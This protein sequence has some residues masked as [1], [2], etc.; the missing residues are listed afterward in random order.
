MPILPAEPE[1]YPQHPLAGGP[2]PGRSPPSLVVPPHQTAPGEDARPCPAQARDFPLSAPN[3]LREPD[4]GRAQD[5]VD[6][7][8]LPGL[9]VSAEE[10]EA[11]GVAKPVGSKP[12]GSDRVSS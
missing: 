6:A 8:A 7:P 11:G 1:M 10:H 12:V 5:P 2:S 4:T 3:R 9:P